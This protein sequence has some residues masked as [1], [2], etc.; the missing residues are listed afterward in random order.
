MLYVA[1][2]MHA[3]VHTQFRDLGNERPM[4]LHHYLPTHHLS[5]SCPWKHSVVLINALI[6]GKLLLE[7]YVGS[8]S[9][10]TEYKL[11]KVSIGNTLNRLTFLEICSM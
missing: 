1:V 3:T 8:L 2:K 10:L 4:G 11:R 7:I 6:I 5:A 9:E